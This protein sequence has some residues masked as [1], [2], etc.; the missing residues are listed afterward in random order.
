M[1][2]DYFTL[3]SQERRRLAVSDSV[4]AGQQNSIVT[5]RRR[6]V[7]EGRLHVP[8]ESRRG[9]FGHRHQRASLFGGCILAALVV[10]YLVLFVVPFA[11]A[12]WLSFQNWDF[13]GSPVFVGFQNYVFAFSDPQFWNALKVTVVFSTVEISI[14]VSLSIVIAYF[15]SYLGRLLKHTFLLIYYLPVV[16]PTICTVLLWQLM[17]LQQGGLLNGILGVFGVPA[18]Q[19]TNS[20]SEALWSV[21]IMVLWSE[22]G[23]GILLFVAAMNNLPASLME[24]ARLD[25]AGFWRLLVSIVLPLV[26]PMLFYQVVASVIGTVQMFTQFFLLQGPGYSTQNLPVYMYLQGFQ[27]FNLGY[28]AAISVLMFLLLL[29]ATLVQLR[30]YRAQFQY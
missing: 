14:G 30:R 20:A 8:G 12:V 26:R 2:G 19:F 1:P 3:R 15:M 22:L 10:Y 6:P 5:T 27:S 24:A 7:V 11:T 21:L 28:G 29:F 17:Y 9:S 4:N 13:T 25:G 18:Q 23:G 16:V